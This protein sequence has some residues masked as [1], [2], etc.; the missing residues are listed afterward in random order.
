MSVL[1]SKQQVLAQL[2]CGTVQSALE[3]LGEKSE[4]GH[5]HGAEPAAV[6][7]PALQVPVLHGR[8]DA[9]G[10]KRQRRGHPTYGSLRHVSAFPAVP[11]PTDADD[12]H[13]CSCW[14]ALATASYIGALYYVPFVFRLLGFGASRLSFDRLMDAAMSDMDLMPLMIQVGG[15]TICR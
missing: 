7:E 6:H 12:L 9:A 11:M 1:R 10:E 8:Q 4:R 3:E 13:T 15:A 2:P 5:A 14:L